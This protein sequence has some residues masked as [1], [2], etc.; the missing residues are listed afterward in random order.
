M[1]QVTR[2]NSKSIFLSSLL[3]ECQER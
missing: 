1:T 2:Y 3:I